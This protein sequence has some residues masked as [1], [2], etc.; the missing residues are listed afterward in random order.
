VPAEPAKKPKAEGAVHVKPEE[1]LVNR[2]PAG[3]SPSSPSR[4]S[5]RTCRCSPAAT[6]F[7]PEGSGAEA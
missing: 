5:C 4:W 3:A 6:V 7:P 1:F 2:A